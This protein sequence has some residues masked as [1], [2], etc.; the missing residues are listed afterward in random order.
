MV[1][2]KSRMGNMAKVYRKM[3]AHGAERN[4][5]DNG[6][7]MEEVRVDNHLLIVNTI[8]PHISIHEMTFVT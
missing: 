4:R 7:R 2:R 8:F 3:G 6:D 5:N 1:D